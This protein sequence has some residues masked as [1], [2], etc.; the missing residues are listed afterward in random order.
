MMMIVTAGNKLSNCATLMRSDAGE[1]SIG[2]CKEEYWKEVEK[3]KRE[4]A[5]R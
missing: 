5:R 1:G 2:S 3:R 4:Y